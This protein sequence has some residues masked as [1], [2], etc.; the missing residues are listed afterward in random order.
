MPPAPQDRPEITFYPS[1]QE[2]ASAYMAAIR[3][4]SAVRHSMDA[5]KAD[6][7]GI[8]SAIDDDSSGRRYPDVP[9]PAPANS[10]TPEAVPTLNQ[11]S[12]THFTS[13][14][15]EPGFVRP[16]DSYPSP[17]NSTDTGT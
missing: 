1:S 5:Q 4:A 9:A 12:S 16:Q 17:S 3:I 10:T 11:T 2:D 7:D 6:A 14:T 15:T 13:N 8:D